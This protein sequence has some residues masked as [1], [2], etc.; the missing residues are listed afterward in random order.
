[1]RSSRTVRDAVDPRIALV[2]LPE[3]FAWLADKPEE[4]L[5]AI[6]KVQRP[7]RLRRTVAEAM[8]GLGGEV[9][10]PPPQTLV[11]REVT[12]EMPRERAASD[13]QVAPSPSTSVANVHRTSAEQRA[14]VTDAELDAAKTRFVPP[15]PRDIAPPPPADPASPVL[16]G[17]PLGDYVPTL[18]QIQPASAPE[19]APE[20]PAAPE[21]EQ[22]AAQMR[23]EPPPLPLP[24]FLPARPSAL[25]PTEEPA[26]AVV[27]EPVPETPLEFEAAPVAEAEPEP[28]A[29]AREPEL[30]VESPPASNAR[31]PR[32]LPPPLV[33][34][35][36]S[37]PPAVTRADDFLPSRGFRP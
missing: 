13:A 1:M 12:R 9:A 7:P 33:A 21:P 16:R 35:S 23:P 10:P 20:Q 34:A 5:D 3:V 14:A 15:P 31:P 26:A 37:A 17:F 25:P 22:P 28:V 19:P 30:Q 8:R 18:P 4:E 29:P 6:E 24:A 27:P 32:L 2:R 36:R 11:R